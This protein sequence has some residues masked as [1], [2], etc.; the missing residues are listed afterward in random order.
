[1]CLHQ[2]LGRVSITDGI[3]M[4]EL[5]IQQSV[6]ISTLWHRMKYAR[7]WQPKVRKSPGNI[8]IHPLCF[9]F[10]TAFNWCQILARAQYC[11]SKRKFWAHECM[12]LHL[13]LGRV[14]IIDNEEVAI[15]SGN[16]QS[17]PSCIGF[18]M[19]EVPTIDWWQILL[20]HSAEAQ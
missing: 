15:S 14:S 2:D 16:I 8:N 1:M 18:N 12:N 5:T 10:N 7:Y 17:H 6:N 19:G 20:D 4:A 13:D 3:L 11:C 9:V